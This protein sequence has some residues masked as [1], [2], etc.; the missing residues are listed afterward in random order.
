ML[1][2]KGSTLQLIANRFDLNAKEI[3]EMYR[4]R[5]AIGTVFQMDQEASA[6]REILRT[7][8][9]GDSKSSVCCP[10]CILPARAHPD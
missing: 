5:W 6:H 9:M 10:D 7:K 2:F 8:R 4:S 3:S 1:D